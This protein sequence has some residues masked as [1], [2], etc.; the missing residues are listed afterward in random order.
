MTTREQMEVW[1][2]NLLGELSRLRNAKDAEDIADAFEDAR[3]AWSNVTAL[4]D[5]VLEQEG[6]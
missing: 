3:A 4:V 5:H 6:A 1:I 2:N